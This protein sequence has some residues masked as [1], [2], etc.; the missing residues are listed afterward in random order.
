MIEIRAIIRPAR[1]ET[2]RQAL[3]QMPEFPG[4]TVLKVEGCSAPWVEQA[5]PAGI[6]RELL[7]YTPKAM[8]IMVAPEDA[9]ERLCA[10][11]HRV[12]HTGRM[13]DGL[14]WTGEVRHFMRIA[15]QPE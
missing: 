11:I 6:R 5:E 4:M 7:D 2:L 9:A 3:R 1:L 10:T 8:V 15:T 14:I 13:G 12:A